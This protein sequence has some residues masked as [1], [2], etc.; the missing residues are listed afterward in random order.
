MR[1]LHG[2]RIQDLRARPDGDEVEGV[3]LA[4]SALGLGSIVW[5]LSRSLLVVKVRGGSMLPTYVPGDIL[6]AEGVTHRLGLLRPNHVV[7]FDHFGSLWVK[8]VVEVTDAGIRVVGDNVELSHDSRHFGIVPRKEVRGRVVAVWKLGA[9]LIGG[10]VGR[11]VQDPPAGANAGRSALGTAFRSSSGCGP[12]AR[13]ADASCAGEF[14]WPRNKHEIALE[15]P[16][17]VWSHLA[18]VQ[19]PRTEGSMRP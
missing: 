1:D 12:A 15:R 19:K 11:G 16:H 13:N 2:L 6:L 8:R 14:T 3:G 4:A 10:S 7:V 9:S 18:K 17:H 5:V